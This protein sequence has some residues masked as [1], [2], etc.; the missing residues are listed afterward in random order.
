MVS[1]LG[2]ASGKLQSQRH[3]EVTEAAGGQAAC[4]PPLGYLTGVWD[5]V[6][7]G[8]EEPGEGVCVG[9]RVEKGSGQLSE[10]PAAWAPCPL[11]SISL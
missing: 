2:P 4:P 6:A 8:L 10:A 9:G 7:E 1:G 5:T 11:C 3:S